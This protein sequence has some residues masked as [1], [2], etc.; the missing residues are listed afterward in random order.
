MCSEVT[1]GALGPWYANTL[2]VGRQRLLHY[3]SSTSL[4]SVVIS[5]RDRHSAE[6]R[7]AR[8]LGEVLRELRAVDDSI[9]KELALLKA[10]QYGRASDRSKLGSL[11]DQANLANYQLARGD[12]SLLEVNLR[13]A[14]TP[15]GPMNYH[16]PK[17]MAPRRLEQTWRWTA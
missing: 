9:E 8:A 5:L 12:L 16:S 4:L 3:M 17:K 13:L 10:V 2:N 14:E 7:F 15:C 1:E 6:H 11:R